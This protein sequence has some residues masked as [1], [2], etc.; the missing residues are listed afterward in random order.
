M[1]RRS[2]NPC[3]KRLARFLDFGCKPLTSRLSQPAVQDGAQL[4]LLIL[5]QMIR[6]FQNLSKR[7]NRSHDKIP[8][9]RW[10]LPVIQLSCGVDVHARTMCVG[11][12][13]LARILP[14]R[15]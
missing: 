12:L 3:R 5:G 13:Y 14:G 10:H 4:L 11:A 9:F 15:V 8:L 7:Q 1:A 2:N 6:C